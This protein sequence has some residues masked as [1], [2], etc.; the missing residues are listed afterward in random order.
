LEYAFQVVEGR[1]SEGLSKEAELAMVE[2]R[3]RVPEKHRDQDLWRFNDAQ[4]T[5][6]QQVMDALDETLVALISNELE[7]EQ[8]DGLAENVYS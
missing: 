8:L 4:Y 7:Y 3:K 5:T 1:V 6:Y 2:V